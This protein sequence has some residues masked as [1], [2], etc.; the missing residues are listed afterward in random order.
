MRAR[1]LKPGF[2]KNEDLAELPPLVRILFAGLWGMA[3]REGRLEDRPRRIKAEVLP[4]DTCDIEAMLDQLSSDDDPFIV[5]YSVDG[6]S[7]IWIPTFLDHQAPHYKEK[8]SEIPPFTGELNHRPIIGQSSVNPDTLNPESGLLNPSSLNPESIEEDD[9]PS[10]PKAKRPSREGDWVGKW[11]EAERAQGREPG[12]G[13]KATF[14]RKVKE[15][16]AKE[17]IDEWLMKD[18][19]IRMAEQEKAPGVLPYVYADCKRDSNREAF[20]VATTARRVR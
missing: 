16:Q 19:I 5:R 3:D 7:Y 20:R 6:R 10:S 12:P 11:V 4:Y 8:P 18:A 13:Q 14:G 2:F 1:N 15:L 9:A 17:P